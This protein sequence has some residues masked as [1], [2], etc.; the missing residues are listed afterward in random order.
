MAKLTGPDDTP[1]DAHAVTVAVVGGADSPHDITLARHLADAGHHVRLEALEARG[2]AEWIAIGRRLK[3]A[4][5]IL[6]VHPQGQTLLPS[7]I[8]TDVSRAGSTE[9]PRLVTLL[10][11][12]PGASDAA[13]QNLAERSLWRRVLTRSHV[14]ATPGHG[15]P[16]PREE[17]R[18]LVRLPLPRDDENSWMDYVG[19]I[20]SLLAPVAA[21]E[22]HR[23]QPA[24]GGTPGL[25]GLVE[26]AR[27]GVRLAVRPR[28][29]HL[30]AY[31]FPEWVRPTDVLASYE[32]ADE[33]RDLAHTLGLPWVGDEIRAWAAL[34]ALAAVIRL[35][36]G[37]ARSA[38][39]L[40]AS[41]PR[42][43][44]TR[45]ARAVGFA[46]LELGPHDELDSAGLSEGSLDVITRLHPGGVTADDLD[47][48]VIESSWFLKPGGLL[49]V[50]VP[51]SD[52]GAAGGVDRARLRASL[53][54]A[55]GHG[56]PLVGDVDKDLGERLR[57]AVVGA[58]EARHREQDE[59]F[60]LVRLTF[61]RRA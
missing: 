7:S 15:T 29:V 44:F 58:R 61:R 19:R 48:T 35:R 1:R 8:V 21:E 42:S 54:R 23:V 53:A 55:D 45:W 25:R 22:P 3:E 28:T 16:L 5:V 18:D 6:L 46:P 41:G 59:A 40:D 4:E 60:A 27:V 52:G 36:D 30:V 43:P 51:L 14:V 47:G 13:T 11:D 56:M 49:V 38:L 20:E 31:D 10:D 32:E 12:H 9:G 24:S 26:R 34:G 17:L 37:S 39:V 2:A 57:D 33:Q 50:T